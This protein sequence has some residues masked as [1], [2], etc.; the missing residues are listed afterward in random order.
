M[1]L[2]ILESSVSI[3]EYPIL[4]PFACDVYFFVE[5]YCDEDI[6]SMILQV[7]SAHNLEL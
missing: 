7:L 1:F 3:I 5:Y 2:W 6:W 4:S